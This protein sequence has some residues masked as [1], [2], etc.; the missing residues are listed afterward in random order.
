VP[1]QKP[2]GWPEPISLG[3]LSLDFYS[4]VGEVEGVNSGDFSAHD[5][6]NVVVSVASS[7]ATVEEVTC[8]LVGRRTSPQLIGVA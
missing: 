4:S 6:V 7:T 3:E 2:D 5:G 8:A 1:R